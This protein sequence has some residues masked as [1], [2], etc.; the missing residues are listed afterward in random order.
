MSSLV[1]RQE[2]DLFHESFHPSILWLH[3]FDGWLLPSQ[4][5][6]HLFTG[7]LPLCRRLL[8]PFALCT[9]RLRRSCLGFYLW[10]RQAIESPRW[11]S[12]F[13]SRSW[14]RHDRLCFGEAA[15]NGVLSLR[16]LQS[17]CSQ[18]FL[19]NGKS[20]GC[21]GCCHICAVAWGWLTW[22]FVWS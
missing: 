22:L 20:S 3:L 1:V 12:S 18:R 16:D 10:S 11:K 8:H 5:A 21:L 19:S 14:T 17:F 2:R 15:W 4:V 9:S 6:E 13:D 7:L